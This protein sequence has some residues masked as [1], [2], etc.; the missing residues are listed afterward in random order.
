MKKIANIRPALPEDYFAHFTDTPVQEARRQERR[1]RDAQEA[2]AA[3]SLSEAI[4]TT[5]M[6]ALSVSAV[7]ACFLLAV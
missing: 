3:M 1:R 6:F 2:S 5:I 7:V 4:Q